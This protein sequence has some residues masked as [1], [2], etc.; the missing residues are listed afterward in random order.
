MSPIQQAAQCIS[1]LNVD[2]RAYIECDSC[3]IKHPSK[4]CS[5][6]KCA[7]Y[8]SVACQRK[9]WVAE[10]KIT[11]GSLE[12]NYHEGSLVQLPHGECGICM[13]E[14]MSHPIRLDECGHSFCFT[15]IRH[16]QEASSPDQW[17]SVNMYNH[18]C[19]PLCRTVMKKN[20]AHYAVTQADDIQDRASEIPEQHDDKMKLLHAAVSTCDCVLEVKNENLQAMMVKIRALAQFDPHN[21][22]NVV[23]ELLQLDTVVRRK[24]R[25]LAKRLMDVLNL[26]LEG[27]LDLAMDIQN[28]IK[29]E[30]EKY[31]QM[32]QS[33]GN[34]SGCL[35]DARIC[36]ATANEATDRWHDAI[37]EYG[38][39]L[40]WYEST[41]SPRELKQDDLIRLRSCRAGIARCEL[42][43]GNYDVALT[44]SKES[45]AMCREFQG[46]HKLVAQAQRA[47]AR[48]P[49]PTSARPGQP[50]NAKCTLMDAVETMYRA[51]VHEAP[52]NDA[53][54]QVNRA[55]LQELLE[56]L[57][58]E[59]K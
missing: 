26:K 31:D 3:G 9:H 38:E 7:F 58:A 39:M 41:D 12:T 30:Y 24:E 8:C 55:F 1:N 47:L 56:E 18:G 10:H 22:I 6:C 34:G 23:N 33:L 52:W 13:D 29:A 15:C 16:W 50:T 27:R 20:V 36:I 14:P 35:F 11:C 49:V 45:L 5:R 21:T 43:L 54:K 40:L 25:Q 4:R 57:E 32:P 28:E 42:H 48:L 44:Y 17:N 59:V 46:S 51:M 19:C 53:N 2:F 37:H